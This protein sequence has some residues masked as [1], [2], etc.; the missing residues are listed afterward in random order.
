[1]PDLTEFGT[2]FTIAAVDIH[3]DFEQEAEAS[4]CT[5]TVG[6]IQEQVSVVLIGSPCLFFNVTN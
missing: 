3:S 1:V 2:A 4:H 5:D 6:T